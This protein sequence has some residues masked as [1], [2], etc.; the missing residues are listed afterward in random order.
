MIGKC[1]KH[2]KQ[3]SIQCPR[4]R[5]T[6][7]GSYMSADV[8]LYSL[9]ELEKRDKM[10]GLQHSK[11]SK[12]ILF[13][14]FCCFTSQVNNYYHDGMVSLPNHTFY[15]A[16]LNKAVNQSFVCTLYSQTRICCQACYRMCY[17]A[18]YRVQVKETILVTVSISNDI[19]TLVTWL[20]QI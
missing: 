15:W 19:D 13:C 6:N 5:D 1:H 20:L 3:I 18:R 4:G 10:G 17:A 2:R 8:L 16:S 11:A 9:N 7:R 14:L 12:L